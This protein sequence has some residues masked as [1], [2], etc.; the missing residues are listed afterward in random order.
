M[1]PS[2]SRNLDS[3][4]CTVVLVVAASAPRLA[5]CQWQPRITTSASTKA[6]QVVLVSGSSP[7]PLRLAALRSN[8]LGLWCLVSLRR[9]SKT[10]SRRAGKS[11]NRIRRNEVRR[12]HQPAR[13]KPSVRS[14]PLCRAHSLSRAALKSG[15]CG[16]GSA[17]GAG[18]TPSPRLCSTPR[19]RSRPRAWGD[20]AAH[21]VEL[22]DPATAHVN[23]ASTG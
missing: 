3:D 4:T 15:S 19:E 12:R 8:Q 11:Q 14:T 20:N 2:P 22:E 18:A 21:A 9:C 16:P 13:E 23:A 7:L 5:H 10:P 17:T 6:L 1:T